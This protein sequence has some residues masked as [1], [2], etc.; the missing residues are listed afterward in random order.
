ML[1]GGTQ[2]ATDF[3][4]GTRM[5]TLAEQQTFMVAYPE[6][7]T[8]ANPNG[9]W[10][11]FHPPTSTAVTASRRSLPAS[12]ADHRAYAVT[13]TQVYVA[14]LSAGGAM[15]AVMAATYPDLYAAVGVHSGLAYRAAQN[16]PSAFSRHEDR[17]IARGTI[18]VPLIVFHGDRDAPWLRST[19][20]LI[21][22]HLGAAPIATP[23]PWSLRSS[24]GRESGR[25]YTRQS[26]TTTTDTPSLNTGRAWRGT[27]LVRRQPRR[28]LHRPNGSRRFE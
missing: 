23:T 8:S 11:W 24:H 21:S 20:S 3:A 27:R 2:D 26:H 16:I 17:R 13:P 22:A 25:S 28:V 1:H 7:P 15:A 19:P 12:R 5:N 14:G 4:A 18:D 10:N 9:Y 6:Q